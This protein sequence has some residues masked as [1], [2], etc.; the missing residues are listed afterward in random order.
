MKYTT[1]VQAYNQ[2]CFQMKSKGSLTHR[3]WRRYTC[4][5]RMMLT[6]TQ[7]LAATVTIG[8]DRST[9]STVVRTDAVATFEEETSMTNLLNRFAKDESGATAIE[10]GLI[11]C[12]ISVVCIAIWRLG[13][14]EPADD[15]H[16]GELRPQVISARYGRPS[17]EARDMVPGFPF[18]CPTR[19]AAR[20]LPRRN[21]TAL[22]LG[23]VPAAHRLCAYRA[24]GSS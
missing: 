21:E 10:Y 22:W 12:L 6:S 18:R 23:Q 13:R 5:I 16:L 24:R 8:S 1:E 2:G 19:P 4:K 17:T 15:L 11:A 14:L 3:Q 9:A 20:L 7:R